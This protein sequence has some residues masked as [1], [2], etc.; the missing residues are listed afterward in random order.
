MEVKSQ[1]NVKLKSSAIFDV[2][3]SINSVGTYRYLSTLQTFI[4]ELR[5]Y[6]QL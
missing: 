3:M 5:N 4:E 1:L 2:L 6:F